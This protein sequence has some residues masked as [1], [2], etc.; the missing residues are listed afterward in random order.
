M[1][2]KDQAAPLVFHKWMKELPKTLLE[3][4]MP[5]DVYEMLP[6]KGNIIRSIFTKR[7]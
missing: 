2:D 6:G 5:E 1:D 7:L 3:E 4:E